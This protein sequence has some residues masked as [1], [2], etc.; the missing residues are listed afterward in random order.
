MDQLKQLQREIIYSKSPI[1]KYNKLNLM[2]N[3]MF[4]EKLP[5]DATSRFKRYIM[6]T[7]ESLKHYAVFDKPP[8]EHP[9]Q[10][11]I[12]ESEPIQTTPIYHGRYTTEELNDLRLEKFD[13]N[14]PR[15][16][17][18]QGGNHEEDENEEEDKNEEN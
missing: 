7:M 14:K 3:I 16:M 18:V 9:I 6:S 8:N 13:L 5:A 10:E 1:E 15:N 17:Y 2:M 4:R 12:V 11:E